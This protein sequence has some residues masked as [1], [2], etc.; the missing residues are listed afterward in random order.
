MKD[1]SPVEQLWDKVA[2]LLTELLDF[3][4]PFIMIGILWLLFKVLEAI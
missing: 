4:E 3:A 1:K 2:E